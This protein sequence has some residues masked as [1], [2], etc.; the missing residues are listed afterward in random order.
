[1]SATGE[2]IRGRAVPRSEIERAF[3]VTSS[4]GVESL[5]VFSFMD[6]G[7]DVIEKHLGRN[8]SK[9]SD[10]KNFRLAIVEG[11]DHTFTPLDSQVALHEMLVRHVV[12]RTA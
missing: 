2:R 4:R 11:A 3:R 9:V 7:I 5:L 12:A 1:M 6:G 8:A 10:L